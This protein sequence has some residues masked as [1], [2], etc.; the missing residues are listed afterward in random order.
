M[1]YLIFIP[2]ILGLAT[3]LNSFEW[4]YGSLRKYAPEHEFNACRLK[5]YLEVIDELEIK[6]EI[7]SS[8]GL[9]KYHYFY[10]S[11]R[12][13]KIYYLRK[14]FGLG[15]LAY[16][17]KM[18]DDIVHIR[19]NRKYLRFIKL[20]VMGMHSIPFILADITSF[21]L[22]RMGLATIHCAAVKKNE[23]TIIIAAAPNTGKTLTCVT[24]CRDYGYQYIAED[25]VITD[26]SNI[27]GVPWTSTFRFYYLDNNKLKKYKTMLLKSNSIFHLL[28]I[29]S[30]CLITDIIPK[31]RILLSSKASDIVLLEN[32]PSQYNCDKEEGIEKLLILNRYELNYHKAPAVLLFNYFNLRYSIADA[33]NVEKNIIARLLNNCNYHLISEKH[34]INYAMIIDSKIGK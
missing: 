24:L 31:D 28:P 12:S 8:K 19:C 27:W 34:S 7:D 32:G 23:K 10:G 16:S 18:S 13:E 30:G 26:G 20:R 4:P 9:Y 1:K 25:F 11:P 21:L 15:T 33:F 6:K 5:I 3:T 2:E 29:E 17:L 22:L 14:L